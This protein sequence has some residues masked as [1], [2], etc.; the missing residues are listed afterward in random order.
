MPMITGK[1]SPFTISYERLNIPKNLPLAD[2]WFNTSS[3]IDMLI[4]VEI[5][6]NLMCVGEI[7]INKLLFQKALFGL[8]A[9][10]CADKHIGERSKA[11]L[12]NQALV[13]DQNVLRNNTLKKFWELENS[14]G[15]QNVG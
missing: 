8:I 12:C 14:C 5:F 10:G 13:L 7:L 2:P 15:N 4:G 6:Y 9:A 3:E 11:V 1:I